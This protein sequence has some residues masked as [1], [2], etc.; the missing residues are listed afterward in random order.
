M[1]T[2]FRPPQTLRKRPSQ[3]RSTLT[4]DAVLEATVQVLAREGYA[5]TTTTRVAERAGVSVGS[6]Y[7]YFPNRAALMV[8]LVRRHLTRVSDAVATAVAAR[9]AAPLPEVCA[10]LVDA[11]LAAK[12]AGLAETRLLQPAF[13]DL[14]I[15]PVVSEVLQ[16][17]VRELAGVLQQRPDFAGRDAAL[18]A[19]LLIHA[20]SAPLHEWVMQAPDRLDDPAIVVA[21]KQLA[22]G[23]A[24]EV[25]R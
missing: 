8:E 3:V 7:Q 19:H 14:Q 12:R 16:A 4:V 23:Y 10:A 1:P 22:T 6:I 20:V 18:F 25:V 9:L 2:S 15:A 24:R 11:L 5:R 21:L 17:G 13:A